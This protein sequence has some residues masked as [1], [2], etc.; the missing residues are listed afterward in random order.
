MEAIANHQ[1]R[2]AFAELFAWYAPRV[3]GY[4]LRLGADDSL[5]E[6]LAQ[7][8]M[9]TIWRKADLFDRRQASVGT[10]VFRIA[11][12]RRI[13]A[14]RRTKKPELDPNDSLLLPPPLAG[15]DEML[16]GVDR[17]A[18]VRLAMVD[19]P[20]EQKVLL[21]QAFYDGLTHREIADTT[22]VPLGTV[23]SRLRLAFQKLRARLAGD[24]P[25]L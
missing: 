20:D 1:D 14:V 18:R 25:S 5:A 2:A 23:K 15:A 21:K 16:D 19:L 10:W 22:G 9:V 11:R 7:D 6:E 24:D 13:D 12:N 4:L 8:V 3:K 17:E